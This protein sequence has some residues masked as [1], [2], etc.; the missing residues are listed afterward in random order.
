MSRQCDLVIF[1]LAGTTVRDDGQVP[2]ALTSA[3]AEYGVT[4]TAEQIAG[5]RGASKRQVIEQLVPEGPNRT[6]QAAAAYATFR[7]RVTES[8]RT[9]G[10][11]EIDGASALF[12]QLRAAGMRVALTTGFDR[13]IT[14]SL[15]AALRWQDG[16]A[17]AVI[18]GDDVRRGRPAPY[19]IFHA[20]EACGVTCV[21]RVAT[22]GDT[23]ND[24]FAGHHAGVAWNVGVV[25]GAHGRAHLRQAPHTHLVTS[26]AELT[27][28][29]PWG[30]P[31]E[32]DR[33]HSAL[34]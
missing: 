21:H 4:V 13:D 7:H 31:P 27:T 29:F 1:D 5:V 18:C 24:L 28:E 3:L 10:A 23:T 16:L 22:V 12:A 33:T 6:A 11:A 26:V 25:S 32:L 8:F 9:Q 19:L 14:A 17:D 30:Q 20:M 15:L 2:V 34:R